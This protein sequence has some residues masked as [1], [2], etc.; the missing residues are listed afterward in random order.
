MELIAAN[1]TSQT[2]KRCG[3]QL[4]ATSMAPGNSGIV[5][6]QRCQVLSFLAHGGNG[7]RARSK[8]VPPPRNIA[9]EK[10]GETL[11]IVRRWYKHIY[12]LLA[13]PAIMLDVGLVYMFSVMPDGVPP[14]E[15]LL[16][17]VSL[18][19]ILLALNYLVVTGLFN[20]TRITVDRR[21]LQIRHE[22]LPW[23]GSRTYHLGNVVQFFCMRVVADVGSG[24]DTAFISLNALC[25]GTGVIK[26][27]GNFHAPE[28]ALHLEQVIEEHLGL[29]DIPV[30]GEMTR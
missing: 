30:R 5:T 6:C 8:Q 13:L 20:R 29:R 28:E 12:V 15:L 2:C 18:L 9:I 23:P 4:P 3:A 1:T 16:M 26:L 24:A 25:T 22:P 19:A 10:R 11:H 17:H 27:I 7:G 14:I 21:W